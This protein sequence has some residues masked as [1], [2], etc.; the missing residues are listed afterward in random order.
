MK[1]VKFQVSDDI[2]NRLKQLSVS[3]GLSMA[4]QVRLLVAQATSYSLEGIRDY[5]GHSGDIGQTGGE[6][7]NSNG[8]D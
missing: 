6:T 2:F 4:G 7:G 1:K 3:N 5:H 8:T